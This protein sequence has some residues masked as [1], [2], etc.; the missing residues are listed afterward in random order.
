MLKNNQKQ[1]SLEKR[2]FVAQ[3]KP[4]A[5][6]I[7][8]INLKNQGFNVFM[9]MLRGTERKERGFEQKTSPLFPGYIFIELNPD[10]GPWRKIN[11]TR[12]ILRIVRVGAEPSVV[13]HKIITMLME[14]CDD[15]GFI[16]NTRQFAVGERAKV[17]LG[18]FSG[19]VATITKV[20]TKS[21]IYILLD[22]LGQKTKAS[23]EAAALTRVS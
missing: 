20:D 10:L 16:Q 7:A 8:E 11:N 2:W 17:A 9:P 4:N 22:I 18:P 14:R 5:V 6:K 3:C 21:R 15:M 1:I 19:L 13:P 23:I 12:G